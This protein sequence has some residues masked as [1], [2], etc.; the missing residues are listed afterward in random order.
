MN[1][2]Q[3]CVDYLYSLISYETKPNWSYDNKSFNLD[4]FQSFL[5]RLGNPQNHLKIIHVAGSDGKG[6]TCAMITSVLQHKGYQVGLFT[7]PHLHSVRERIQINRKWITKEAFVH[8]TNVLRHELESFSPGQ[9]GFT[10]FFE[11]ITAMGFLYFQQ[12]K[13]DFAVIE[14]GLGGRLDATNVGN[15]ILCVITHIS[16]EHADKLGDTLE[17]IADEKLGIVRD[18]TPVVIGHQD[19][20]LLPHF[21]QRLNGHSSQTVFVDNSYSLLLSRIVDHQ[22]EIVFQTE[23]ESVKVM[24]PLLGYYQV[25]NV[26]TVHAAINTLAQKYIHPVSIQDF[27]YGIQHTR[28]D[29]RFEVIPYHSIPVVLDIA[30]TVKGAIALKQ[31]VMEVYP[32]QKLIF[33]LGFLKDKNYQEMMKELC[34][35]DDNIIL[36]VPPTPRALE[37][38]ELQKVCTCFDNKMSFHF[39][40]NVD[41]AF[42]QALKLAHHDSVVIVAGSLYLVSAVRSRLVQISDV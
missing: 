35:P 2:Y 19:D 27:Q 40:E 24:S 9:S 33:V 6:S 30:H 10:T 16:M 17:K 23:T 31:S 1:T 36:T 5:T 29:G 8:W 22:R 38:D 41:H 39:I 15:P 26:M 13:V 18:Q 11:L 28:W 7:S 21:Y 25:Q 32:K 34:T 12:E 4:R 37:M 14:T 3:E 20:H 42:E